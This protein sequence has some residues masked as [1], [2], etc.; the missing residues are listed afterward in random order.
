MHNETSGL[1]F[2]YYLVYFSIIIYIVQNQEL[3]IIVDEEL[4]DDKD[5]STLPLINFPDIEE[6]ET[7]CPID[8]I[9]INPYRKMINEDLK[10]EILETI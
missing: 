8:D 6:L 2:N 3:E 9:L 7:G 10:Q 5:A 1:L 4:H